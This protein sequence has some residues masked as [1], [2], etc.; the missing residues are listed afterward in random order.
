M[1]EVWPY[2]MERY[3]MVVEKDVGSVQGAGFLKLRETEGCV[4]EITVNKVSTLEGGSGQI[5][6]GKIGT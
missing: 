4:G 5:T 6:A 1:M 3:A 2:V